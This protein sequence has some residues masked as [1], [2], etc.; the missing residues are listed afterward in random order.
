[1][2]KTTA[3]RTA[4]A[5]LLV[6]A[7]ALMAA[8]CAFV[9]PAKAL[10]DDKAASDSTEKTAVAHST[11]AAGNKTSYYST[12]EAL[13]AGYAGVKIVMDEDWALTDTLS[14][15][16]GKTLTLDMNGKRITAASGKS[17][18]HLSGNAKLTLTSSRQNNFYYTGYDGK[19]GNG[20]TAYISPIGGLVTGANAY[21]DGGGVCMDDG[22]TLT[23]DGIA[24][25]GNSG[26]NC[27]G[28]Y[29][30]AQ[31]T[32]NLQN[33]ATVAYNKGSSGGI[34]ISG[35][36]SAVNMDNASITGNYA[37][38]SGGGIRCGAIGITIA[39]ENKSTISG[40]TAL[41][42][43]G[44]YLDHT[45]FNIVSKDKTGAI[46]NND[47]SGRESAD[48]YADGA[49]I[50]VDSA[51]SGSGEISGITVSGNKASGNAGGIFLG[52]KSTRV[53]D[54]TVTN[55][56]AGRYAGGIYVNSD[57]TI[58]SCTVTGNSSNG[59]GSNYPGGG[60]YVDCS[61][62][63]TLSG[64]CTITDNTRGSDKSNRDDLFLDDGYPHNFKHAYILGGVD[65]GSSVGIRTGMTD[66][67][68]MVGKNI[69]TYAAGTYFMDL[70]DY[71]IT[72]G[73]DHNGDLWQ[74]KGST[75]VSSI[76]LDVSMPVT[77]Y[78]LSNTAKLSWG[79][80]KSIEVP[81]TW[82][83]EDGKVATKAVK[84]GSYR[85]KLSV[86]G[87]TDGNPTFE[88]SMG[89]QSVGLNLKDYEAGKGI[90]E[91]SVGS[92]GKLNVTSDWFKAMN[93]RGIG[94]DDETPSNIV[95]NGDKGSTAVDATADTTKASA[96]GSDAAG[97]AVALA[98]T[99]DPLPMGVFAIVAA[100]ALASIAVGAF[101][102]RRSRR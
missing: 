84:G 86:A 21:G 99:G 61:Y 47:L 38:A 64:K 15:A 3:R 20:F 82:Y 24:V 44:I 45:N 2:E 43:G 4:Q 68:Q 101:A 26:E 94:G 97:N 79:T 80:D 70:D 37:S 30:G 23:L 28:I 19:T 10:A 58:A 53:S 39:M 66:D 91:V 13:T 55:N 8:L 56:T 54:C 88:S 27:G 57:C 74:R 11:D 76:K 92:N 12:S 72:H 100:A 33:G 35:K 49:G 77:D 5:F 41:Y 36:N 25:A 18:I 60:V 42:G 51:G 71:Y 62:D 50:Y 90:S 67:S 9:A 32:L 95:D 31:C 98:Q 85:F 65:E 17:A 83:D 87:G 59:M 16:S 89:V 40:N 29:M 81:I 78:E 6:F 14:I 96:T 48:D 22:S 46:S 75:K 34:Y 69:S 1:M 52:Q 73:T 102:L 63:V 7:A 93:S